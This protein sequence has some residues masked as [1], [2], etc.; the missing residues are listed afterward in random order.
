MGFDGTSLRGRR[1]DERWNRTSVGDLLERLTWSRPDQEAIV[2]APGAFFDPAFE[3]V[4]YRHGD[5]TANRVAN[6]VHSAGLEPGDRV[7]LY[8]DNSVEALVTVIGIAKA[9][10]VAVAVNPLMA[11]GVLTWAVEHVK[12]RFTM[13]DDA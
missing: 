6:A 13:V 9:G 7:L 12:P 8:C 5:E 11:P 2:G 4:T 1:A 10:L 3:R